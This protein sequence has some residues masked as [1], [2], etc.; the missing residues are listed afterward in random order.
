MI[1][2][3]LCLQASLLAHPLYLSPEQPELRS[4]EHILLFHDGV[5]NLVYP[6]GRNLA[7]SEELMGSLRRRVAAGEDFRQLAAQFSD[8]RTARF[9]G[10]L[11]SY[12]PGMLKPDFDE[13]LFSAGLGDLSPVLVNDQGVHLLRRTATH[14]ALMQIQIDGS[15]LAAQALASSLMKQLEAGADFGELAT[16]HSA[17]PI[18]RS[19]AGK[20]RVFERGPSDA[21]IKRAAFEAPIG[22]LI[23][24]FETPLG[25]H[26]LK[27][28]EPVGFPDELWD[29]NF[30]RVRG[31]LVT[32]LKARGVSASINR[33]QS[34][35][36]ALAQEVIVRVQAGE[37][38]AEI[39]GRFNDDPGGKQRAGDLGWIYRPNP[40]LP[41][42]FS[43]L[44]LAEPGTLSPAHLTPFGVVVLWRER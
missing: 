17:D 35:A 39:A 38:F 1:L 24:P 19:H 4:A 32:H 33:T 31:I 8:A 14:A 13:F 40:D 6:A 41:L 28:V 22:K 16:E 23:G 21:L 2:A 9:G 26:I 12:P 11:G 18:S 10:P 44:F 36:K 30:I 15:D 20:F 3:T 7:Q 29:H 27:R 5:P 43:S 34:E 25:L 37:D 42:F